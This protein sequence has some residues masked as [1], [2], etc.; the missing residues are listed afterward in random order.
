MHA[1]LR[2]AKFLLYSLPD[3]ICTGVRLE[4]VDDLPYTVDQEL[5]EIPFD[6]TVVLE[7]RIGFLRALCHMPALR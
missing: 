4:T 1:G 7:I 3:D 6:V 2:P 5:G